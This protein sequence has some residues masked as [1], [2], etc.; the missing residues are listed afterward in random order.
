MRTIHL[1]LS[2]IFLLI[3]SIAFCQVSGTVVDETNGSPVPFVNV[4]VKNTLLGA[5]T[6]KDGKFTIGGAKIGDSLLISSLGYSTLV[7]SAKEE[8]NI[9]L[10]SE[11]NKLD[12]VVLIP[13]NNSA[14]FSII[15]YKKPKKNRNWYNNGH[16]SL[17][18]FYQYKPEYSKTP[19]IGQIG[20][21]TLNAK[22]ESVLFRIRL[23][24]IGTNGAPSEN[25]LT[26]NIILE[27]KKGSAEI[28]F[29][30]KGEKIL[31][32]EDGFFVVLDRLNL[33][34]NKFFNKTQ[35]WTSYNQQLEWS[36]QNRKKIHGSGLEVDGFPHW[37]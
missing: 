32:P 16:Y 25:G 24:K 21:I 10:K 15:S 22:D 17:A 11:I 27:S 37:K 26:D 20:L 29:D 19:F 13:M 30:L 3:V 18:R 8:N 33:E 35:K 28:V 34:E 12:E 9:S 36:G 4:W 6:G 7:F 23:V 1:S 31:F 2:I 5:T 14:E